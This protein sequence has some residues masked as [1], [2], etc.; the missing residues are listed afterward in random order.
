[1][2]TMVAGNDRMPLVA[3]DGSGDPIQAKTKT[4]FK[5][6]C[7]CDIPKHFDVCKSQCCE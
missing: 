1:M 5:S 6:D 4:V 3:R 2:Y 7:V